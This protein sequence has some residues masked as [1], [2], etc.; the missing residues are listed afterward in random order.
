VADGK[1]VRE[2]NGV[3]EHAFNADFVK[4]PGREMEFN[5]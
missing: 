2:F 5:I 4:K 3:M 1:E